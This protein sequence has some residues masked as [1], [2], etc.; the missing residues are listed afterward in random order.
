MPNTDRPLPIQCPKCQHDGSTLVVKSYTV[1]TL[2]CASCGHF[3]ATV[4]ASLPPDVQEEITRTHSAT[5]NAR[6][7]STGSANRLHD[8]LQLVNLEGSREPA[9]KA[10]HRA[11]PRS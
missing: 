9:K 8:H 10:V 4:V 6:I 11:A 5:P 2:T 3:W 1:M 7:A